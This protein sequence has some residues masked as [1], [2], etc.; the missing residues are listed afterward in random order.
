MREVG[1]MT[2][3]AAV[4]ER[5]KVPMNVLGRVPYRVLTAQPVANS[6]PAPSVAAP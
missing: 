6:D 3:R 4:D 2:K 1:D 5:R